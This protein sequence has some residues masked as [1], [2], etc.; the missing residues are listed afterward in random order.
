MISITHLFTKVSFLFFTQDTRQVR[1]HQSQIT[2]DM[3]SVYYTADSTL[4]WFDLIWLFILTYHLNEHVSSI[5]T[6]IYLTTVLTKVFY[7]F[8]KVTFKYS[9]YADYIKNVTKKLS[10]VFKSSSVVLNPMDCSFPPKIHTSREFMLL[11]N[12][13]DPLGHRT[14]KDLEIQTSDNR[15]NIFS[16]FYSFESTFKR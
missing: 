3:K 10:Y 6:F 16:T 4:I 12:I 7:K 15:Y 13:K 5:Y 2:V 8:N 11:C 14:L 1:H 9:V